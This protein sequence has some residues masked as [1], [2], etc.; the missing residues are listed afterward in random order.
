VLIR[1]DHL[2]NMTSLEQELWTRAHPR[3]LP[4]VRDRVGGAAAPT[5]LTRTVLAA[6]AAEVESDRIP[7]LLT[8]A[9]PASGRPPPVR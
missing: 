2:A 3:V 7:E 4:Q 5:V 9:S 8:T 6:L 1:R